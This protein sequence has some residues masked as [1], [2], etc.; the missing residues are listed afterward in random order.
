[1]KNVKVTASI[2]TY[3]SRRVIDGVLKSLR[4]SN[5]SCDL[6]TVVV[7][8]K[9]TDDTVDYISKMYPEVRIIQNQINAGYGR[10]NNK[11]LSASDSDYFF[12]INPDIEF[13]EDLIQ[14]AVDY[15][16]AN[17]D[18][19]L[20][21]P[22]IKSPEGKRKYPPKALP[23]LHYI[24]P[25]VVKWKNPLFDKW[26]REYTY[27]TRFREEPFEVEV[28]SGSFMMCRTSAL[29]AVGGFDERFFLYYEDLDLSRMMAQKGRIVC[30]PGLSV[31]H[32]GAREAHHSKT[33]GNYMIQSAFKYFNKWG[34]KI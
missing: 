3:N 26:R 21:N 4:C 16:E 11:A 6:E 9:S 5:C 8:N 20:A 19:V 22:D 25:R 15:L 27:Q 30:N 17:P 31:R 2:V 28:C 13:D 12:V 1:M 24:L 32:V 29:K 33:A 14:K 18:I 34:W 7:D 23:A 10:A